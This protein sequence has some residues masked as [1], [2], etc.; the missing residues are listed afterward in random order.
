MRI[1][2][3]G[4]SY[5]TF[6]DY[7]HVASSTIN[8]VSSSPNPVIESPWG[9]MILYDEI[10]FLCES[11]CP[12]NM[13]KLP[14]VKY[15]DR[16]FPDLYFGSIEKDELNMQQ[17]NYE[18]DVSYNKIMD[19]MNLE[20]SIRKGLDVHTHELMI[21]SLSVNAR[22]DMQN[23]FVDMYVLQALRERT[24]YNISLISNSFH[25]YQLQENNTE[26]T[27][28]N[29]IIVSDIPNYTSSNGPYHACIE[30]LREHKYLRDFRKWILE[31]HETLQNMEVK[32]MCEYV[33]K[34]IKEVENKV[35]MKYLEQ[36]DRKNV[37]RS[38]SETVIATGLGIPYIGVSIVSAGKELVSKFTGK[39][40]ADKLKWVGYVADAQKTMNKFM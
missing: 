38:C 29:N 31:N 20:P 4:L 8:D 18:G 40:D 27:V 16:M 28:A 37:F 17:Y 24:S 1:A 19:S 34:T 23:Y 2:Y 15:V 5:P 7:F 25:Q 11:L 12:N 26:V 22:D 30:E 32:E 33:Q 9:L 21:C 36:N 39:R 35:F 14:Y 10:W 3:I 13:R 6:Y